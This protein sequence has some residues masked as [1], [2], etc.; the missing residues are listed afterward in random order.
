M[1]AIIT[2][3]LKSSRVFPT[4]FN[5]GEVLEGYARLR[6][7]ADSDARIIPGHD[8]LVMKRYE[9]VSEALK[10]VAVRLDTPPRS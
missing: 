1:L 7:L 4:V 3:I 2:S 5:V 9:Y 10:D 6:D 8:P